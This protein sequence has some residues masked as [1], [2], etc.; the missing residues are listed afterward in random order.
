MKA[1]DRVY[2]SYLRPSLQ[3]FE[4]LQSLISTLCALFFRNQVR[5]NIDG[6][7]TAPTVQ[8]RGLRQGDSLSPFLFNLALGPLLLH[9]IH[10][11][12]ITGFIPSCTEVVDL[13]LALVTHSNFKVPVYADDMCVFLNCTSN[14]HRVQRHFGNYCRVSNARP[15]INKA[16]MLSLNGCPQPEWTYFLRQ[17]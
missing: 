6:H 11:I 8:E 14:F 12:A 5:I 3:H 13:R 4:F 7:F 15:H 2:P 17:H 16:E 1:Y 10:D 9:I